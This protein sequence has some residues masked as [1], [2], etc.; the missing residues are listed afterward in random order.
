MTSLLHC[1]RG[2][3]RREMSSSLLSP[4]DGSHQ[5]ASERNMG[6]KKIEM[7]AATVPFPPSQRKTHEAVLNGSLLFYPCDADSSQSTLSKSTDTNTN[8][9]F[10]AIVVHCRRVSL[11]FPIVPVILITAKTQ[12][13]ICSVLLGVFL[14]ALHPDVYFQQYTTTQWLC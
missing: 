10:V 4:F 2:K 13:V 1:R 7:L 14:S 3:L 9:S 6:K 11:R 12:Q 5:A 8:S